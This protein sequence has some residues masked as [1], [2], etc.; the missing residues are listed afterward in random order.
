MKS[1]SRILGK[2][3]IVFTILIL[4]SSTISAAT[5]T[6]VSLTKSFSLLSFGE[7]TATDI[8]AMD[9]KNMYYGIDGVALLSSRNGYEAAYAVWKI[10]AAKGETFDDCTFTMI[11]RV[12]Y[13]D[14]AQKAKNSLKVSVST[15]NSTYKLVKEYKSTDNASDTQ[16]FVHDLTQYVKGAK[17][18]YVRMDFLV[19]D[20]PHIIGF[21][22]ISLVGNAGGQTV[23]S[24]STVKSSA[25][26]S[27][28]TATPTVEAITPTAEISSLD[29]S[30]EISSSDTESVE[31]ESETESEESSEPE[32][33][34][35][36]NTGVSMGSLIGM[37][38]AS[39]VVGAAVGTAGTFFILKKRKA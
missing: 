15:D 24:E 13:Q 12:W 21:R 22:S 30:S 31:S 26:T 3:S 14:A 4:I 1:T 17:T 9:E 25:A 37:M 34:D 20:S 29:E 23:A 5:K 7:V 33:V 11:G 2:I 8:G 10:D 39:F 27:E 28:S 19:F 35:V 18:V 32:D 16:K 6:K 38:I 36:E